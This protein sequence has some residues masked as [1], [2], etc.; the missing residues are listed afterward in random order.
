VSNR[1]AGLVDLRVALVVGTAAAVA[2][3]PA[4]GVALLMP[5]RLSAVLFSALL[6]AVATQLTVKTLRAGRSSRPS[7]G[8]P[9]PTT[10]AGR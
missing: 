7:P 10:G 6:I 5:A 9:A 3:V 1:R 4:A 2:A 8:S